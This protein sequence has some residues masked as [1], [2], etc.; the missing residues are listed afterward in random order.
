MYEFGPRNIVLYWFK[1]I[2]HNLFKHINFGSKLDV[3]HLIVE[4]WPLHSLCVNPRTWVS[5]ICEVL[6]VY[7]MLKLPSMSTFQC[8]CWGSLY[9][10]WYA[11][12]DFICGFLIIKKN[13]DQY[14]IVETFHML[15]NL[16]NGPIHLDLWLK[17]QFLSI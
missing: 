14:V 13:S 6:Y 5:C 7:S 12:I 3:F 17:I 10:L 1:H 16:L 15:N 4:L 11:C 9:V 8:Y 2:F